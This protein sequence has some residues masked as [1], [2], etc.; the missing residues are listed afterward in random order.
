MSE[1]ATVIDVDRVSKEFRS[2]RRRVLALDGVSFA[3]RRGEVFGLLGAN[4]AGKTT[5]V[6]ILLGLTRP[7]AGHVTVRGAEPRRTRAR[8]RVGYLPEGHRFPGYL[9]GEAAMR[10]FGRLAGLDEATITRRTREL[11]ALVGLSDRG[12]DRIGRYSKGMTQR[13]GL[14]CALL[15]EPEVL[16]LDEPTDGV[17]PVGRRQIR[18]VLLDARAAGTTI[19]INSHLLSEVERTCDRVAILHQGRLLREAS[20]EDLTRPS[21]RFC[22]RLEEGQRAPLATLAPFGAAAP[23]GHIE[24]EVPDLETLNRLLDR[25]RGERLLIAEVTP[26]RAALEDV[27]IEL[28]REESAP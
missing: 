17:D 15:D 22:I 16:F 7:T 11:L 13:L 5:L 2:W 12:S 1:A 23:N 4:G 10:L 25:L 14:A 6:K 24:V 20:V 8:R 28:V 9:S 27:F 18:D 3:V 26:R 19:F 21:R